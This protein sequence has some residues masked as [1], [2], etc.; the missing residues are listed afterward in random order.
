MKARAGGAVRSS[1]AGGAVRSSRAGL[2]LTAAATLLLGVP[3]V[4]LA[5]AYPDITPGGGTPWP[6]ALKTAAAVGAVIAGAALATHRA[7]MLCGTLL[8]LAGPAVV[9]SG[10][11]VAQARPAL[12]FTIVLAGSALAPAL[13]GAAA[14][15]CPVGRLRSWDRL[16]AAAGLV[17]AGLV[18][19]LLPTVLFDP[20]ASGCFTCAANL[21]EIHSAPGLRAGLIQWGLALTIVTGAGTA[22]LAGWRWLQAPRIL[23]LVNAPVAVGG[24][25]VALLSAA[26]A[27]YALAQPVAVIGV[28]SQVIWLAQCAIVVLI[29]GGVAAN[30]VRTRRLA[31]QVAAQV[32]AATPDAAALRRS[33]AQSIDDPSLALFFPRDNGTFIDAAGQPAEVTGPAPDPR[34][35]GRAVA[36]ARRASR[37]VAEVRYRAELAGAEQLLG[38]AVRSAGLALEHVAAQARL[39]A[40]VADLAASRR[41]IIED[42]DAERRRLERD[43]HDGAQQ[44]L[45][46]LQLFLQLAADDEAEGQA[47]EQAETY[48]AARRI[49]GTALADL[50]DLAH[51]I[52]PA[53][54]TDDGLMTGL[55]T[56]ANRSPVPVSIGGTGPAARSAVAEAAAYR[57]VAYTVH[58][59]GQLS[60]GPTIRVTADGNEPTLRIR[61][62]ADGLGD[63]QAAEIMAR[64]SDRMAAANGSITVETTTAGLAAAR[65]TMTAVFPCASLSPRTWRCCGRVWPGCSPMRDSTSSAVPE[66]RTN[67]SRWSPDPNRTPPS[68]TS[69]CRPRTPTRACARRRSSGNGTPRSPSCCCPAT[70]RPATPRLC[71]RIIRRGPDTCSKTAS[72]T[73]P[74]WATRCAG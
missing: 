74:R 11:P 18:C 3:M 46:G 65:T 17:V 59:A 54:L 5:A 34:G 63:E 66:T 21:A 24:A 27:G 51:G 26:A 42:A 70:W 20:R 56:L 13:L 37:T 10:V 50:R 58:T 25:A 4:R 57:L 43:L 36:T 47:G 41:R 7:T 62:E 72:T 45:I 69:R 68:S 1:R 31:S 8:M 52:H 6:L 32:L 33:L 67:C 23:R 49:V 64:A 16:V 53:A 15:T 30:A 48:L 73:R 29:A 28:Q 71:S 38:T 60:G 14:L 19:G 61:I 2:A 22:V 44:R 35:A 55:R 12:L 39:H 9:I 40:E